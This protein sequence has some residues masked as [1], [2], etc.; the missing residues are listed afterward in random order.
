MEDEKKYKELSR[1]LI[2][3]WQ[4]E[5]IQLNEGAT[6]EELNNF[7]TELNI[8]LPKDFRYFY[9]LVNGMQEGCSDKHLFELWSLN[10]ILKKEKGVL[11]YVVETESEVEIPF[12]DWLIDSHRY[13]LVF[14]KFGTSSIRVDGD[15]PPVLLNSFASFLDAYLFNP[16][17]ICLWLI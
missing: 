10:Y 4:E 3:Q 5:K 7:E 14:D 2:K 11:V 12:G 6:E 17:S 9:S 8:K 15:D 16:E 1:K 13:S